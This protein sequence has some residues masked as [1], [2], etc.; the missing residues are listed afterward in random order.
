MYK[1]QQRLLILFYDHPLPT[2]GKTGFA[3]FGSHAPDNGGFK[4]SSD[5]FDR[6]HGSRTHRRPHHLLCSAYRVRGQS[7]SS[8]SSCS[9]N[10]GRFTE[11]GTVG[12]L[13]RPGLS[14]PSGACGIICDTALCC[15]VYCSVHL[16]RPDHFSAFLCVDMCF[17]ER[18]CNWR[19]GSSE[20]EG[21]R[22]DRQAA[23]E[24]QR[25]SAG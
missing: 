18:V 9:A 11:S 4:Q 25:L 19:L 17:V 12:K 16:G 7:S 20:E 5:F 21:R 8:L 13:R 3:A 14:K 1:C 15:L 10:R 22:G 23:A 6:A 24:P 2:T